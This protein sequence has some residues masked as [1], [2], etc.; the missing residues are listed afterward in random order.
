MGDYPWMSYEEI[1]PYLDDMDRLHVSEVARGV[2]SS[3]V[4]DKGFLEVY[5]RIKDPEDMEYIP[6][7]KGSNQSWADRRHNF[8]ARHLAQYD[9]KPTYRRKLALIAWAY[10]PDN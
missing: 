10:D 1:V 3:T 4:S 2:K 6:I 7:R 5:K 8:V 9:K